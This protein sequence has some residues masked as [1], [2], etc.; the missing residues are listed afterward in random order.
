M[1]MC[2]HCGELFPDAAE[3]IPTHDYP[4]P[5]RSV[6]PGSRQ[7]PRNPESD[8]RPLWSGNPNQHIPESAGLTILPARLHHDDQPGPVDVVQ[9]DADGFPVALTLAVPE[10][11]LNDSAQPVATIPAAQTFVCG[12]DGWKGQPRPGCTCANCAAADSVPFIRGP[13]TSE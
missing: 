2:P 13:A 8:R 9:V 11:L 5:C 4:K 10:E 6:C 7:H 12:P 1:K 3:L